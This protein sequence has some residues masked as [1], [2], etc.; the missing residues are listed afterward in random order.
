MFD[1]E[2]LIESY[3]EAYGHGVL[4][5]NLI[6]FEGERHQVRLEIPRD[7]PDG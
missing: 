7:K 5:M 6:D 1:L 3:R 2:P 4:V